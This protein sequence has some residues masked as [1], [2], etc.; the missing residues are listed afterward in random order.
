MD[1]S[2]T[3][4]LIPVVYAIYGFIFCFRTPEFLGRSGLATKQSRRSKETWKYAHRVAGIYCFCAAVLTGALA[5]WQGLFTD[6]E[7][8]PA[9]FWIRMVI[10]IGTIAAAIPVMNTLTK[11]K[12]PG[13]DQ[14]E[15]TNEEK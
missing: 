10:E 2:Y 12:F 8:L 13:P 11:R 7:T 14:A 9:A 4:Y 15:A 5:Y 1:M 6:G 3:S